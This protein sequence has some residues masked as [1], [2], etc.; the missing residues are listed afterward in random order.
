MWLI[1][2][3][4]YKLHLCRSPL[5]KNMYKIADAEKK[6]TLGEAILKYRENET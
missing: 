2:F 5:W 6:V 1:L 4:E 3:Q